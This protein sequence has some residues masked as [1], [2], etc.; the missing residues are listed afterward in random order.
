MSKGFPDKFLFGGAIAANQAEGA[1]QEGFKGLGICD[2]LPV[3]KDRLLTIDPQLKK[4]HYY[5]SHKAIDFYHHVE[6][7]IALL[8][9][10]GSTMLSF[11]N[12]L[13][14]TFSTWR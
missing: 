12:Q 10:M 2:I 5:P 9:E 6:E 4:D 8:K 1:Y 11:F 14:A 7:D 13:G 3:G